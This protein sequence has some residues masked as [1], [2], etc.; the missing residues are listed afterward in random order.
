MDEGPPTDDRVTLLVTVDSLRAD[1]VPYMPTVQSLARHGRRYENAFAHGN[2]TPFSFPSVHGSRS[3]FADSDRVGLPETPSL[4]E[5]LQADG[6]ETV[7]VNAANGLLTPYW[8]Y[9]RG[10]D[11]FE[12]FVDQHDG[13]VAR[14]LAAHPTVQAWIGLASEPLRKRLSG[15]RDGPSN[16]SRL[17]DVESRAREAIRD[18][19]GPLFCWVHYMDTHTPYVP[20]SKHVDAVTDESPRRLRTLRTQFRAGRGGPVDDDQLATLRTLYHAAAHQVDASIDRLLGELE[21][22][23][24]REDALVVVAGDHGEEFQEHGHLAHYP[25]LH[26]ELIHVPLVVDGPGVAGEESRATGL[27]DVPATVCDWHGAAPPAGF[28]GESLLDPDRDPDDPVCS[29]AVRGDSVTQQPIPRRLD[30]GELLVSA[31]TRKWA[32]VRHTDS[33]E[34]ALYDRQADRFEQ[35]DVAARYPGVVD[36]LREATADYVADLGG[37]AEREEGVPEDLD[38]QLAA[39][40]YK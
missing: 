24:R 7:G 4:A 38:R 27:R 25:K 14:R 20:G 28:D 32:Y 23:G 3:V 18:A 10:F 15:R 26:E 17:A 33:G 6:V 34:Q 35:D 21:D 40:G 30:E 8:G 31:R 19:D 29:V 39:L 36:R 5:T 1:A 12:P 11:A 22:A 16:V 2:W 13:P 9:D 37:D